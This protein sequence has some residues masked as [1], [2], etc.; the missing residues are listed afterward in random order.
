MGNF[1]VL[2]VNFN[3]HTKARDMGKGNLLQLT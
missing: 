1:S 3:V 2:I